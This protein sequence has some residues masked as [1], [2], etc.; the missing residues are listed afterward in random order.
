MMQRVLKGASR[1]AIVGFAAV[2]LVGCA[3]APDRVQEAPIETDLALETFD[4]AW[5]IVYDTHFDTAFNGVDWT[6]LREELR[7]KIQAV[8]SRRELRSILNDMVGRLGQSHF[9]IIPQEAVDTLDP[10]Q[11]DVSGEVGDMGLDVRLVG[12][13]VVVTRL[14]EGGAAANAGVQTGWAVLHIGED[15]VTNLLAEER[16]S[17]SRYSLALRIWQRVEFRLGGAP[18]DVR[19]VGFL[20][21]S[22][23]R[24]ELEIELQPDESEPV[25][26]GNLPT[27]FSR[28]DSYSVASEEYA[29]EVGVIWFNFWMVPLAR[30]IDKAV[31]EFRQM[32]GIV[33]DLRGNRGG[34][35]AMVSGV[36]GHFLDE[37]ISLGTLKT[38]QTSLE[39]RANPRRVSTQRRRVTPFDGPVA[40]L[41]DEV[42]GS[43]SEMFAGGMQSIGRVRVFGTTSIGG[44]LPAAMDR[45]PNGDVLYH[46][47]GDFVTPDGVRLEGRGVMPDQPVPLSLN[48]LLEGS[49]A[50]LEAAIAW[51][52]AERTAEVTGVAR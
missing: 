8:K 22:G 20:D 17:D 18:G 27:F 7:P 46:A 48:G 43:A 40:I 30:H 25:K 28:F 37:P 12:E 3:K 14:A 26:F 49:D 24:R 10:F 34:V 31:D 51:I 23:Q 13:R 11:R 35:G 4:K 2:T 21:G 50:P 39:M 47:F 33:I 42:S 16:E 6:G 32:D 52:A 44:V 29:V 36:A 5:S 38:R 9:A 41:I 45:L 15:T 1:L 19:R